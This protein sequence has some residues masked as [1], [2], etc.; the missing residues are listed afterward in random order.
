MNWD[1]LNRRKFPRV[2]YPC[3]VVIRND[4]DEKDA[5]LTHTE[6]IGVGGVG[7]I[8][9]KGLSLFS[10]VDVELDLLDLEEHVKCRGKVVWSVRRKSTE[11]NKPLFYDIGI[12]FVDA[13]EKDIARIEA[14]VQRLVKQGKTVPESNTTDP[15]SKQG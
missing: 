15:R 6:N 3:Q 12:E 11:Q 10:P 2:S 8:F 13:G 5:I 14:A 1:G 7:V 9:R 4:K